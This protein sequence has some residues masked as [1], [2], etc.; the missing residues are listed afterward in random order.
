MA[1]DNLIALAAEADRQSIGELAVKY[2]WLK[3]HAE[4][5]ETAKALEP[6][7]KAMGVDLAGTVK[8]L[9]DWRNWKA[10]ETKGWAWHQARQAEL[11]AALA[12]AQ[13]KIV[14]FEARTDTEM[15]P[16]DI[17]QIVEGVVAKGGFIDTAGL[18][19]TLDEFAEKTMKPTVLTASNGMAARFQRLYTV[20]T[21]KVHSHF[22]KFG[23]DLDMEA[24]F[25][26]MDATGQT[27]PIKAYES[28]TAPKVR[29]LEAKDWQ[30]KVDAAKAEGVQEGIRKGAAASGRANPSDAGGGVVKFGPAQRRQM[31]RQTARTADGTSRPTLGQ[32]QFAHRA[33][34]AHM[35]KEAAA[36]A[37]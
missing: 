5:G 16:E 10:D 1:F 17:R 18:K 36:Q 33:T 25:A 29:E 19:A 22:Q 20:L 3:E 14:E 4:L 2:P 7:L 15:S 23:E 28:F 30:A 35:E 8:E 13:A 26:H 9:E 31:E 6:R 11:R 32:G 12:D 24:V 34:V 21:P 27:D 37:D